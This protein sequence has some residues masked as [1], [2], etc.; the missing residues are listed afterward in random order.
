MWPSDHILNRP[1]DTAPLH[2]KSGAYINSIGANTGLK[3]DF[4]SGLYLRAAIGIPYNVV[5]QGQALV[6]MRFDIADESDPGPY[7]FPPT[8]RIEGGASL[9]GDRHVIV[10]D[11]SNCKLYETFDSHRQP[12]NSWKAYGG[13]VFNLNS[14]ALRPDTFSSAD[15]AGLAILPSLVRYDDVISGE[16][17][18]ALRFTA[19]RT[20]RHY[21][22]PAT[23]YASSITDINVPPL[24]QRFRLKA[25]FDISAFDPK[26][27][28]ILKALKKYGL[29]LADNGSNWFISG[30]PDN[31]WDNNALRQL[32]KVLGNHMEAVDVSG[33]MIDPR[34]AKSK[35]H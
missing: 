15:A 16:I 30:V 29:V 33:L 21:V 20:Q 10:L 14:N 8:A 5:E 3:A 27:Q 6:A 23:H 26:V 25:D 2:P 31:R 32:S 9:T 12:D 19:Q 1:I 11:K 28:V 22:W 34:S 35:T 4:G 18:H 17:T 24:G 7:P 13:A